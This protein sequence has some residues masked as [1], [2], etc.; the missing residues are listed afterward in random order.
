MSAF[1]KFVFQK[2]FHF[3]IAVLALGLTASN[4][5]AGFEWVPQ[6]SPAPQAKPAIVQQPVI[7]QEPVVV[8][9]TVLPLPVQEELSEPVMLEPKAPTPA[10]VMVAP[11]P[12]AEVEMKKPAAPARI[13]ITPREKPN[14]GAIANV[15]DIPELPKMEKPAAR[16]QD[17]EV[18]KIPPVLQERRRII[19][20]EDAPQSARQQ[21]KDSMVIVP[22]PV[23]TET[24]EIDQAALE[25]MPEMLT[26]Q[27][28]VSA[29]LQNESNQT[30]EQV[31][32][33]AKDIP[34]ALALQQVVPADYS[35]SFAESV[36]P[37]TRV[38]WNGGK[39]WDSVIADMISPLGY[40]AQIRGKT[41]RIVQEQSS[42]LE[43]NSTVNIAQAIEPAAGD[44]GEEDIIIS[45]EAPEEEV[46]VAT[47]PRN[48]KRINIMD[49]GADDTQ[50]VVVA[51]ANI[52]QPEQTLTL[53]EPVKAS[54]VETA[55]IN[56]GKVTFWTAEAG[57]SLKDTISQW[58]EAANAEL[59]WNASND[60]QLS[61]EFQA[62]GSFEKAIELLLKHGIRDSEV[63]Y[64]SSYAASSKNERVQIIIDSAA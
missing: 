61:S 11:A 27:D 16:V 38:S 43:G 54:P 35:F 15:Q 40:R 21:A 1:K 19:M 42:S 29:P 52:E 26:S 59:V 28:M 7:M 13:A 2:K 32:G 9:D 33:F 46:I 56:A 55:K 3:A 6:K 64:E 44:L 5:Y 34:L 20:P 53:Q 57:A 47:R 12:A 25:E 45:L 62:Q 51:N 63:T 22:F 41:L 31:E 30:F 37:G 4:T 49:P 50:D 60:I 58:S 48:V 39:S 18:L 14:S 23:D 10:P 8:D 24:K 17:P 36:N